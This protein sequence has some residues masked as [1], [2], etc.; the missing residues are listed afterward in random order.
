MKLHIQVK[1]RELM[2]CELAARIASIAGQK[3]SPWVG[4][5]G[6]VARNEKRRSD[7][8]LAQMFSKQMGS[9]LCAGRIEEK[10][11]VS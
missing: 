3:L 5:L 2:M 7:G 1:A 9:F 8:M 6:W 10:D 11:G 4:T